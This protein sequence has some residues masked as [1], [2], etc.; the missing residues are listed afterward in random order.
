[1]RPSFLAIDNEIF[2]MQDKNGR[3]L[4]ANQAP[5]WVVHKILNAIVLC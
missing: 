2:V 5:N 4:F 3:N 1:M